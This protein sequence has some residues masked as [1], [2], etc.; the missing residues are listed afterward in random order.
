MGDTLSA[1]L[2]TPRPGRR[3]AALYRG[4]CADDPRSPP[5]RIPLGGVD[6][7]ELGRGDHGGTERRSVDGAEVV[8]IRVVDGRMSTAHARISRVGGDWVLEDLGSKN[9]TWIGAER[10]TRRV[11]ADA[12]ALILGHTAFVFRQHAGELTDAAIDRAGAATR[13][14]LRTLSPTLAARFAELERA[15]RSTVPVELTGETGTGKELIAR[16]VHA[17]SGRAGHLVAINCGALTG[18]LLEAELFGHRRGAFTGAVEERAG[19]VRSADGGTL[20]LDEIAE[21]PAEAQAALLRVL[22]DGEVTPVGGDRPAKVDLRIVTATHRDLDAEVAAG[23]FRAD[24]RARLLGFRLALP[25]LRE[26]PEDLGLVIA[27][28]L[29]RH[30]PGR[31]LALSADALAA[32][33]AHAW[34]LNIR[35]L[36][37][38][39]AAAVA[40]ARDR[41]ELPHLP[42]GLSARDPARTPEPAVDA[43]S[44]AD[45]A[46]RDQL[47]A[48]IARHGGNLAA[49]ARELGKDRTQI[50][51]WMK[52][53]GLARD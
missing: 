38:A 37:R 35:E 50:R 25:P 45:R 11:L 39:L 52:R 47:A 42:A 3:G 28:L 36:E 21:L 1:I 6:R 5:A 48:A 29:D 13:V 41:I 23:R 18:S 19:L 17:L 46:L 24:L 14:G 44:A 20:F 30:A 4:L 9:G 26:R 2:S 16:A 15:A 31:A 40:L 27:E 49:V 51:R 32:L 10:V 34:P 33:Y 43:L 7:V 12:D 8:Q 53:F 22:Q